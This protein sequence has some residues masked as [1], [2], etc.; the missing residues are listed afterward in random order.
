MVIILALSMIAYVIN[1]IA[2][3]GSY[4]DML[5]QKKQIVTSADVANFPEFSIES[6]GSQI[7]IVR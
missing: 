5:T 3:L 4:S 1:G 6:I 7:N 2:S